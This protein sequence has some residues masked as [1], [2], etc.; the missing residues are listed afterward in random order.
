MKI[1]TKPFREIT[2]TITDDLQKY[3]DQKVKKHLKEKDDTE[4]G[5]VY[6]VLVVDDLTKFEEYIA[7]YGLRRLESFADALQGCMDILIQ[8]DQAT[9]D[10]SCMISTPNMLINW[11]LFVV[12]WIVA[13]RQ[14]ILDK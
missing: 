11:I 5:S 7:Y 8:A 13:K 1:K 14:L 12:R 9:Q 10:R 2:V 6:D 4:D 3:I